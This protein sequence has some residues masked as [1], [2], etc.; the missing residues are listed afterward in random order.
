MQARAGFYAPRK[1]P[2]AEETARQEIADA[3]FS[4][5]EMSDLPVEL[6]AQF[7]KLS[8]QDATIVVQCRLDPK[9]LPFRKAE[10][11][12][13]DTLTIVTGVFDNNGKFLAGMVKT[14]DMKLKEETLG[15]MLAAGPM[16]V[17]TN[18]SVPPGTYI[19]RLVVRDSEGQLMSAVN[20]SIAIQ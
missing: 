4:R 12:N 14:M 15:K 18:F 19:L 3:L 2:N 10:G 17:K 5:E 7:F 13:A 8:D 9:R 16:S 1:L 11:R 6:H 20:G